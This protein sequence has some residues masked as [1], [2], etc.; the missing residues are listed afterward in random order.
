MKWVAWRIIQARH[1]DV[2]FT[3]DGARLYGGWWNHKGTLMVYAAGSVSLAALEMLA[4]LE[5]HQLLNDYVCIPVT[6]D[7]AFCRKID[8]AS[9]PDDWRL[10]PVPSST[11][12]VGTQ[13][14]RDLSSA[15]LAVPSALV[16]LEMNFLINP[17]HPD[18]EKLDVGDSQAFQYDPRLI[19]RDS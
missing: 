14:T 1:V 17:R 16:P 2:A 4:H 11:K 19:K 10:D 5:T 3:G 9:L 8:L 7:E 13:W 18:F 12:D 15:V 6:F